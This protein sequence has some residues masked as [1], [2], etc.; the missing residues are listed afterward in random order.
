M[1][2]APH[3]AS[4]VF[5]CDSTLSA[6]EGIDELCSVLPPEQAAEV[7]ALTHAAMNGEVPL[8]DVYAER[9]AIV[10]PSRE[11]LAAVGRRYV[12]RLVPGTADVV[13]ALRAAGVAVTIVSG[14]LAPAVRVLA[15]ALGIAD[16]EVHAVDVVFD[17]AGGYVDFDHESPLWRNLG[18]VEVL[19]ALRARRAPLLFVGDGVTDLEAKDVVDLFV[20]FGGVVARDAIR[21]GAD[22][23]VADADLGFV[24]DLVFGDGATPPRSRPAPR[25][26]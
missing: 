8:A 13:E 19:A 18:K 7:V 26:R 25:A 4:V 12:E 9:L 5:D 2:P 24:L 1:Q 6:L 22:V 3:F 15:H 23:F 14:G 16:D 20:G 11:D 21:R 10:R 17:G